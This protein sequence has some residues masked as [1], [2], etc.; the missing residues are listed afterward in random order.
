MTSSRPKSPSRRRVLQGIAAAGAASLLPLPS[1]AAGGRVVVGTW[2]GDYQNLQ[3]EHIVAPIVQPEG[4]QVIFATDNDSPRKTKML[5]EQKLPRGT[6]DVTCLSGSG[7]YE[8]YKKG[9]LLELDFA[10]LKNA[11]HILPK[12]KTTYSVPHI[13]SDRVILYNPSKI[14]E[15]P[16]S[17]TD[18]WNPKYAGRVGVIDIQY[19]ATIES[20]AMIAGGGLHDYEPGK[21]KLLELKKMGVKIVPTNEAMAQALKSEEI[22]MCIMWK[23][24]GVMWQNAGV[25]IKI[26]SPKEGLVL[27]I[28]EMG[29]LK[30]APDKDAA[31][32]YLDAILDP[33][34]QADFITAMGYNPTI[35]NL[36]PEGEMAQRVAF[37]PAEQE[38][39]LVQD[40]DYLAKNDAQ[41]KEWWDK[42]FKA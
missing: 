10:K 32:A 8:M 12:L 34:P 14:A 19:Q 41:I 26:A 36:Q 7:M 30:N 13:F 35:D 37:T 15:A 33:R 42:E 24:R 3:Q 11:P 21:A 22:W 1:R 17:Y 23:A 28:S 38:A 40:Y 2:G 6:M 29:I 5:A 18:L 4:I 31:Y 16:T 39:M 27:Y 25:P 9:T 20:A